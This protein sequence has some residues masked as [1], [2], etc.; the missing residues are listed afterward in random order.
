MTDRAYHRDQ[1]HRRGSPVFLGP[2]GRPM[3]DARRGGEL[4]PEPRRGRRGLAAFDDHLRDRREGSRSTKA[5]SRIS[6]GAWSEEVDEDNQRL[7]VTVSIFGRATPVE[8]GIHSGVQAGLRF[9][10]E[11]RPVSPY[12]AGLADGGDPARRNSVGRRAVTRGA[13]LTTAN[14]GPGRVSR[15]LFWLENGE[16]EMAKKLG[17]K[18]K[19]QD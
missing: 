7:K 5:R 6:T 4:D 14:K 1:L 2:Q 13:D 19:L 16:A 15:G 3:P 8:P 9:S 12:A 17:G 11:V 18:M 10:I